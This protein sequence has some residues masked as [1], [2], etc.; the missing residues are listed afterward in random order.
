VEA[1]V[2][3]AEARPYSSLTIGVLAETAEGERRVAAVP[4]T[5]EKYVKK[6][7]SVIV[8]SGAGEPANFSNAAYEAVGA[9]VVADADAVFAGADIVAKVRPPTMEEA[10]KCRDGST[11]ISFLYPGANPELTKLLQDRN[12]TAFGMETIPRIS[13]AQSFDALSSMANVSGYKAVVSAAEAFGRLIPGQMTAAGKVPPAKVLVIGAGVAGLAAMAT[14]KSMGAI[15]RGFDTRPTTRDQVK[16]VGA[17]FLDLPGFELEEGSGG[18]AKEMSK[19]FIDAEMALFARQCEDVDIVITTA[20]IPGKPAPKLLSAEMIASMKPGSVTVDLAAEAGGNIATT[21]PGKVHVTDNGVTCI[22]WTDLPSRLPT[23]SSTLYANNIHN[24][25]LSLNGGYKNHYYLDFD[26]LVTRGACVTHAHEVLWPAPPVPPEMVGAGGGGAAAAPAKAAKEVVT[27]LFAPTL[28]Q[29]VLLTAGVASLLGFGMVSPDPSFVKMMQTLAL[30][31]VVGVQLVTNVSHSLHSP[32]MSVTN[33][34]SGLTVVGGLYVMDGGLVP[35]S[36]AG[37]LA[38]GAVFISSINI[39]GGFLVTSR[40]L[41]MFKRP[42]DP[43]EHNRLYAIPAAALVGGYFGS[44]AAGYPS[45]HSSAFT[46]ASLACIG[47]IGGLASQSTARAGNALG[48][49]GV[50]GGVATTLGVLNATPALYTQMAGAMVGGSAI[51]L[52]VARRVKVTDLPQLVAAFHAFVGVAASLTCAAQFLHEYANFASDP[53][54]DVHKV[55]IVGGTFI[56]AVTAT[57][58]AVAYGKLDGMLSSAALHLPGKNALNAA[59]VAASL[60]AATVFLTNTGFDQQLYALASTGVIAGVLGWH[61]TMSIGGA[62]AP[63]AVCMLNSYSGLALAAEGVLLQHDLLLISGSI[64][65]CSGAFLALHM[66]HG[67]NRSLSN[68][69]FGGIA[70]VAPGATKDFGEHK[71]ASTPD[72]V[73]ALVGAEK[74]A[75]VPGYGLA[76]AGAQYPLAAVHELLKGKGKSIEYIVHPVA[77]R[78]PGQLNVLLSEAGIPYDDVFEMEER[79]DMSEYDVVL[80]LGANDTVSMD[81]VENPDS[82]IAG[83]PVIHVWDAKEVF[84]S[85]RS[86]GVGYAAVQNPLF[87]HD[88]CQM[89]LGDAKASLQDLLAQLQAQYN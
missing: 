81:A 20:L 26:D 8:Q 42:T 57:G 74:I 34:V 19:E 37:A 51:G 14:A 2:I 22:G 36:T 33:A 65:T 68:V 70:A 77:G 50:T 67:M 88:R 1:E 79:E 21:V 86:M 28:R 5:I 38:L 6:G 35:N 10:G 62:D 31:G 23:Q 52:G 32:L 56:G 55:A 17:E 54:G 12:V 4:S 72:V 43:T 29:N 83:M 24:F 7:F 45:L 48:I 25:L 64:I 44:M 46:V 59:M 84:V 80:V 40:M 66:C 39:G 9:T 78:M 63:V 30:S 41:D 3:P 71:E 18:Y 61:V 87:Y 27:D 16:S 73:Q 69:I 47:A 49:I 60:G 11:L 76:V 82:P 13:R 58:S 89:W 15:V 85:K 75:V 53:M